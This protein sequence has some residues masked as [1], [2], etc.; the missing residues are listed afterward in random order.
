MADVDLLLAPIE[1]MGGGVPDVRAHLAAETA[2]DVLALHAGRSPEV[3]VL[4]F[5]FIRFTPLR[6]ARGYRRP[7][8]DSH[9]FMANFYHAELA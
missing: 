1:A 8:L 3:N 4:I 6:S 7:P 5:R 2:V 9:W